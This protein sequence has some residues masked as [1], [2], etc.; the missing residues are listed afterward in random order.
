VGDVRARQADPTV[1]GHPEHMPDDA[2][3][4]LVDLRTAPQARTPRTADAGPEPELL[5]QR[6]GELGVDTNAAL[7]TTAV[8]LTPR[9]TW[10]DGSPGGYLNF[11]DG[12]WDVWGEV[13]RAD[14]YSIPNTGG[15]V[16][17]W[18]Q[19]LPPNKL[20]LA[21]LEVQAWHASGSPAQFRVGSSNTGPQF[22]AATLQVQYLGVLFTNAQPSGLSLVA[23]TPVNLGAF[24]F[25]RATLIDVLG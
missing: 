17:I 5:A 9:R 20:W 23:L 8:T 4:T 3:T 6:L 12:R 15:Q 1:V 16:E 2:A 22:V 21:V 7:L 13:D 24:A 14:W 18:F 11:I 25:Y 19:G 10:A